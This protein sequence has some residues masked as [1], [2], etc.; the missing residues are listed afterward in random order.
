MSV[1]YLDHG[2]VPDGDRARPPQ[3]DGRLISR[4]LPSTLVTLGLHAGIVVVLWQT[5]VLPWHPTAEPEAVLAVLVQQPE[6]AM[7]A[8]IPRPPDLPPPEMVP[9]QLD[10][11]VVEGPASVMRAAPPVIAPVRAAVEATTGPVALSTELIVACPERVAPRYPAEAKRRREQGTVV[12]RVEL[13]EAGRVAEVTVLKPSGSRA[14]DDAGASAVR[15]WRCNPAE[16]DGRAVRAV[17]TQA[18]DFVLERR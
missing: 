1:E 14:L 11:P 18:L 15:G 4:R 10:L 5:N 9:V 3:P 2:P 17:A 6:N 13:D 8:E 12:L 7:P 16:R